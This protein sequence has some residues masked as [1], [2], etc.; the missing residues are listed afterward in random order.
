MNHTLNQRARDAA[1]EQPA[2]VIHRY[3]LWWLTPT[4]KRWDAW[5]N[6]ANAALSPGADSAKLKW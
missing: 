1:L 5:G 4:C 3:A 2:K 6:Q